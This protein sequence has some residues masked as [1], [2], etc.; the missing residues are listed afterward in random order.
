MLYTENGITYDVV[1]DAGDTAGQDIYI[2]AVCRN[3]RRMK[4]IPGDLKARIR[5]ACATDDLQRVRR[6]W[7]TVNQKAQPQRQ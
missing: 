2:H 6:M 4:R 5:Q 1:Y 7:E 3:G